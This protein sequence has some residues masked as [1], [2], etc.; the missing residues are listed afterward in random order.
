MKFKENIMRAKVNS[1]VI[2]MLL[3]WSILFPINAQMIKI[4]APE[5]YTETDVYLE[6]NIAYA[7]LINIKFR[8][9]VIDLPVSKRIADLNDIPVDYVNLRNALMKLTK[10][11][12]NFVLIKRIPAA[13][14][15]DTLR[16]NN[17]TG[18]LERVPDFSQWFSI[19]FDFLFP[20]DSVI[21]ILKN[22]RVIKYAAYPIMI[23]TFAERNDPKFTDQWNF[24]NINAR[25]AWD[26][27]KGDSAIKISIVDNGVYVTHEDLQPKIDWSD[28]GNGK[29]GTEVAGV[30]GAKTNNHKGVASLGW[31][32]KLISYDF[33]VTPIDSAIRYSWDDHQARVIN[34]SFGIFIP[35]ELGDMPMTC[36]SE[37][38]L[39]YVGYCKLPYDNPLL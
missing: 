25:D 13:K 2:L 22:E 37:D 34:M 19:K 18:K 3:I 39:K 20:V 32:L 8:E 27:T 28:G 12:G 21:N 7:N 26:I 31:N 29:H 11:F 1:S 33:D 14:Y 10:R 4:H 23:Q 15:G 9:N 17:L 36:S 6:N 30:A 38:K 5:I 24:D 16:V 35:A